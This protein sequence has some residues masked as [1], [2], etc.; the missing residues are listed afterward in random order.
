M[1][2]V[3]S[4]IKIK[5]PFKYNGTNKISMDYYYCKDCDKEEK[6]P[7]CE[8]CMS[9][10]HKSHKRSKKHAKSKHEKIRCSCAMNNHQ[11]KSNSANLS[12]NVCYFFEL[13][14]RSEHFIY[15]LNSN[16]VKI[17][18]FCY[19]FCR[20]DS[21]EEKE[22]KS[23]FKKVFIPKKNISDIDLY[24]FEE[25]EEIFH[26]DCPELHNSKHKTIDFM[27]RSLGDINKTNEAYF[28]DLNSVVILNKFFQSKI[29]FNSIFQSFLIVLKDFVTKCEEEHL[30]YEFNKILGECE[31]MKIP[32]IINTTYNIFYNNAKNC[33]KTTDLFFGKEIDSF[34]NDRMMRVFL[35]NCEF[36]MKYKE[37]KYK[38]DEKFYEKFLYC[39]KKFFIWHNIFKNSLR[40]YKLREFVN[41]SPFQRLSLRNEAR[42]IGIEFDF[43]SNVTKTL[44]KSN[45][46]NLKILMRLFSL[47]KI[48]GNY[49]LLSIEQINDLLK[50]TELIFINFDVFVEHN[51]NSINVVKLFVKITKTLI[52]FSFFLNDT[53]LMKNISEYY[54]SLKIKEN[55]EVKKTVEKI[56]KNFIYIDSELSRIISKNTIHI[57][58]YF[59][60]EFHKYQNEKN[61]HE[62]KN[63]VLKKYLMKLFNLIEILINLAFGKHDIYS[64]G[65]KRLISPKSKETSEFLLY[66][67]CSNNVLLGKINQEEAIINRKLSDFYIDYINPKEVISFF[68]D[69]LNNIFRIIGINDKIIKEKKTC[70]D[71]D[72]FSFD[73]IEFEYKK[74]KKNL[75]IKN[76]RI[77]N[78]YDNNNNNND[79]ENFEEIEEEKNNI[80]F[81]DEDEEDE[82]QIF[83]DININILKE[84][85]ENI[86]NTERNKIIETETKLLDEEPTSIKLKTTSTMEKIEEKKKKPKKIKFKLENNKYFS[87]NKKF[88][89]L[90]SQ[91]LSRQDSTVTNRNENSGSNFVLKNKL[92][93]NVKDSRAMRRGRV[94]KFQTM[95]NSTNFDL[96]QHYYETANWVEN[97]IKHQR[98]NFEKSDSK[99]IEENY[100]NFLENVI[101]IFEQSNYLITFSKIFIITHKK[102]FFLAKFCKKYLFLVSIFIGENS[103]H[104]IS[105]FSSQFFCNLMGMPFI[106]YPN[107]FFLVKK[108][109]KVLIEKKVEISS[110][111][112]FLKLIFNLFDTINDNNNNNNN[113][114]EN[115]YLI[116]I[117]E[118]LETLNLIMKLKHTYKVKFLS[119][120]KNKIFLNETLKKYIINF[121]EYLLEISN[122][123]QKNKSFYLEKKDFY[124]EEIFRKYFKSNKPKIIY[125]VIFYFLINVSDLYEGNLNLSEI[126]F[127]R[128]FFSPEDLI[129]ITKITTLDI[130]LRII[131]IKIF[132]MCY[133]DILIDKE[134]LNYYYIEFQKILEKNLSEN[135]FTPEQNKIFKF[136]EHIMSVNLPKITIIEYEFLLQEIKL[137]EDV[138]TTSNLESVLDEEK[139]E[140][141]IYDKNEDNSYLNYFENS[142]LLT[143]V[144]YLN[145]L[146]VEVGQFQGE[147]LLKIYKFTYYILVM[148]KKFNVYY[149][150]L[151]KK[152]MNNNKK[153]KN[154]NNFTRKMTTSTYLDN[155]DHDLKVMVDAENSP[156]DYNLIYKIIIK[157]LLRLFDNSKSEKNKTFS[158]TKNFE[159]NEINDVNNLREELLSSGIDL[160]KDSFENELFE[161]YEF[162][163]NGKYNYD[164]LSYKSIFDLKYSGIEST[165]RTVFCKY[166]IFVLTSEEDI[167]ESEILN[168]LLN[169]LIKETSKTQKSMIEINYRSYYEKFQIIIE[170]CFVNIL[171]SILSHFNPSLNKNNDS[172]YNSCAMIK[173]FKYMCEEHNKFF[174]K[175]FLQKYHY[176]LNNKTK[177]G[178]YDMFLF[179]AEKLIILSCWKIV[180]KREDFHKYFFLLFSCIIELLIEIV[181]GTNKE[182]FKGLFN[183]RFGELKRE[184]VA[185]SPLKKKASRRAKYEEGKA[186][187]Q[188]LKT[189]RD[190]ILSD[191]HNSKEID[192]IRKML[193][194]FL[195]AFMEEKNC[196]SEI[197]SMINI[198]F[199]ASSLINSIVILL[200]KIYVKLKKKTLAK[201]LTF[202]KRK[203]I[204]LLDTHLRNQKNQNV[205]KEIEN[206][207]F[208]NEKCKL[209]RDLY[210]QDEEFSHFPS[211]E[212]C[213]NFYNY[214]K[215]ILL[216]SHNNDIKHFWHKI[217][218]IKNYDLDAYN[219]ATEAGTFDSEASIFEAYYVIKLFEQISTAILVTSEAQTNYVIFTRPPCVYYL[220]EQTK[221]YFLQSVNRSSRNSKLIDLM[222]K[223]EY[224]KIEAE[225]NYYKL[226][227]NKI[228]KVLD[229]INYYYVCLAV[230]LVDCVL[231]FC[232]VEFGN[233]S[234][235]TFGKEDKSVYVKIRVF[236]NVLCIVVF[237]V[238]AL[239]VYTKI[240]LKL[241]IQE[242]KFMH[243][244]NIKNRNELKKYDKFL[245]YF[246]SIFSHKELQMLIL[247]LFFKILGSVNH[248]FAFLYSFSLF[249]AMYLFDTL[250]IL[251][252]AFFL[253]G[254][255]LLW[256][257]AF[258][259]ITLYIYSGWGFFYLRPLFYDT[260]RNVAENMC[261]SLFYCFL[262]QIING[263]RWYPGI[264]KILRNESPLVHLKRYFHIYL[265]KYSFYLIIR[266]MMI[267]II[268]GIILES[269]TELRDNK[270]SIERDRYFR[271]FICNIEKDDCEKKNENF[272]EHCNKVHNVWNYLD[273]IIMLRL[274]HMQDLNGINAMC[275]EMIENGVPNWLP[276]KELNKEE[277]E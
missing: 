119:F 89:R 185:M 91:N 58:K 29:L 56:R 17:C 42:S 156:L 162:Y 206:V 163:V 128:E 260:D 250:I 52:Y 202:T 15:Y 186:L 155:I 46:Q 122:D 253:K 126:N 3:N 24:E 164:I 7:L 33:R 243:K 276:E 135:I 248:H 125:K 203:T 175:L 146:F 228:L 259:L 71:E 40:V 241:K 38:N 212:L 165:F 14:I 204:V 111:F 207:Y 266:V 61:K 229:S 180:R 183:R 130:K 101:D 168:I 62:K 231:N 32:K 74:F 247:F 49:Y 137:F 100:E 226:K 120:I 195:L 210:F 124:R 216:T 102:D 217:R 43:V 213:T 153:K 158:Y 68:N 254:R 99:K 268:F 141:K 223:S 151:F 83:N 257:L 236:T 170:K 92:N 39:Y 28:S 263:F 8:C 12:L 97:N 237:L 230:F 105:L 37:N 140:L 87:S 178:F 159:L 251:P 262:T 197:K 196:P 232:F 79:D 54:E 179:I 132:R 274:S 174:Q 110:E 176:K 150:G 76:S 144:I 73:E 160:K 116:C 171:S 41:L 113:F 72:N 187:E 11:T 182:N 98:T 225:Y 245:I 147:E 108:G 9:E 269:F 82:N 18:E 142:V 34:F 219:K 270:N 189:I 84:E 148:I 94:K 152:F 35:G 227:D 85:D 184:I 103:E 139:N 66:E 67:K 265:Y 60:I 161:I 31:Y 238:I 22:F 115:V 133:I 166:L 55:S 169:M 96:Q 275:K 256:V 242:S 249:G 145:K 215:L 5:C 255:Q 47:V 106:F 90:V 36:G 134:R 2:F 59:E 20:N 75:S 138:L 70:D 273:Y 233:E 261:D 26:C 45:C 167:Y 240:E 13:N 277:I 129:S 211:F 173:L 234:A 131:I 200:K 201:T 63:V 218:S 192:N 109:I 123:F 77:K 1:E 136:Y 267:K 114:N 6:F 95:I 23:E 25:I 69:S 271:C 188:F 107:I 121:K 10:C 235:E 118:L 19:N 177:I 127:L 246:Y 64:S 44:I 117:I 86:I 181:Q 50:T 57:T 112:V 81:Y 30:N 208:N 193:M 154:N 239:W 21:N 209:F 221:Y 272:S 16:G 198:Y 4:L 88:L 80:K 190:I 191:E 222:E 224:F 78:Y 244:K 264:G 53:L 252:N 205:N 51:E 149:N 48:F 143:L 214:F 194:D 172:Y 104:I 27:N 199:D 258:T 93:E 157:H 220:S 65:L